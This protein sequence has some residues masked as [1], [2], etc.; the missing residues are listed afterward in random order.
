MDKN[1]RACKVNIRQ[2]A[3]ELS[4]DQDC[5]LSTKQKSEEKQKAEFLPSSD[6]SDC[7]DK[8]RSAVASPIA[9]R[10]WNYCTNR[11]EEDQRRGR[12]Q[13]K[14]SS[15]LSDSAIPEGPV[16]TSSVGRGGDGGRDAR[17]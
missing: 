3:G 12:P 9:L 10:Y 14:V 6:S 15:I 7:K 17:Q 4:S 11:S 2:Q 1:V 8:E 5:Q 16:S 13:W